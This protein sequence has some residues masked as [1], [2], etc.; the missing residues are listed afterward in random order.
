[1]TYSQEFVNQ[2]ER[3]YDRSYNES[4]RRLKES[5]ENWNRMEESLKSQLDYLH[6]QI[7]KNKNE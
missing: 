6:H 1:M 5:D 2:L 7:D 3:Q 4:L